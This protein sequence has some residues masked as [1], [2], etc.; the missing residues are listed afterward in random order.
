M[1]NDLAGQSHEFLQKPEIHDRWLSDY[2][3]PDIDRYYDLAF[4]QIVQK[5]GATDRTTLL[6]AGCGYCHHTVRIARSGARITGVDFSEAALSAAKETLDRSGLSGQVSLQRGDLTSLPLPDASFDAVI[7]WGVL[8]HIPEMDKALS[9]FSRVLKH[10]GMLVLGE[11]NVASL[12]VQISR[13][14]N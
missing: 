12:D 5:I 9:E 6:D 13:T 14:T 4:A 8:M 10:G 2:L 7:C 11:N 3:N 1:A